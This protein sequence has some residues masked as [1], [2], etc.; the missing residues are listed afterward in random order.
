ME[1]FLPMKVSGFTF[2]RNAVKYDFPI[3]ESIRSILP[4]VDEMVIALGDSEDDTLSLLKQIDSPKIK[5]IHTVWDESLREGGKVLA[6]ETDKALS[7]ISPDSDWAFYL[8][9][10]EIVHE[11]YL[12]TIR[13]AMEKYKDD[14]SVDGLLFHYLHFYGSYDYVG[15]SRNWYRREIRIVRNGIGVYSYRDAQGFRKKENEKLRV[16]LIDAC[17][18]HYGWVKRPDIQQQKQ[19]SSQRFYHSDEEIQKREIPGEVFDYSKVDSL[20]RFSGTHPAVIQDRIKRMN[21]TFSYDPTLKKPS[22]K[23]KLLGQ[24]EKATGWRPFEYRNYILK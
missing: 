23:E 17:I 22:L 19:N 14:R 6:V 18:Y 13:Q 9:G 7:A 3:L 11:K 21:W 8:Q 15:T 10:D 16:K 5:I 4:V 12:D 24:I 1:N 20:Q 2:I